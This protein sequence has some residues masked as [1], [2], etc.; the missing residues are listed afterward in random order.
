MKKLLRLSAA[1][2]CLV[3]VTA[4]VTGTAHAQTSGVEK[5]PATPIATGYPAAGSGD[6]GATNGYNLSRWGER[7]FLTIRSF[8]A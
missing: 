8:S 6:G 1:T 2:V 3:P 7:M 4:V 5:A